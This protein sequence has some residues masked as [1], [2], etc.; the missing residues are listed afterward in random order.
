MEEKDYWVTYKIDGRWETH[1]K[2]KSQEEAL[3]KAEDMYFSADF[4]ELSY[5]DGDP[6]IVEDEKGNFVWEK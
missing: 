6:I 5:I 3:D 4:G 2:A 1:V